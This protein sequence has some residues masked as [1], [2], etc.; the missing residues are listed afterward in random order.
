MKRTLSMLGLFLGLCTV[1]SAQ[2][3]GAP[4]GYYPLCYSGDTWTGALSA[5][6]DEKREIALTYVDPK[7][8][9]T[10]TFV[11]VI[12]D[13]YTVSGIGGPPHALKPSE[14]PRGARLTVDYCTE[15]KKV[16]G[17]KTTVNKVFR[18]EKVPNLKKEYFVFRAFP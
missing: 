6:D 3:G 1:A 8:N 14:L 12:E 11:G 2:H 13:G 4:N 18:I 16:E 17:K 10:E 7:Q 15:R 5:V 9:R